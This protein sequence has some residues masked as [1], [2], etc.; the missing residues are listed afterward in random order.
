MD[1]ANCGKRNQA[2]MWRVSFVT[3][4]DHELKDSEVRFFC[5]C[6]CLVR[7]MMAYVPIAKLDS[8][9]PERSYETRELNLSA[10]IPYR[11]VI[12]DRQGKKLIDMPSDEFEA[13]LKILLSRDIGMPVGKFEKLL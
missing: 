4:P 10:A 9:T 12:R 2:G 3:S 8:V 11:V 1:C 5:G 13:Y 7:W 6:R